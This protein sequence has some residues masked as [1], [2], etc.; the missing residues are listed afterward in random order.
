MVRSP[1][2]TISTD[3]GNGIEGV[4]GSLASPSLAFTLF[5]CFQSIIQ[6][7]VKAEKVARDQEPV[8]SSALSSAEPFYG[9]AH[10]HSTGLFHRI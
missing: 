4:L 10:E 8:D 5:S 7:K 6:E 1:F 3:L 2:M 9:H